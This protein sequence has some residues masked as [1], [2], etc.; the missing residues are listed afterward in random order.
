MRMAGW[1]ARSRPLLDFWSG[2]ACVQ[3][4]YVRRTYRQVAPECPVVLVTDSHR[5]SGTD[6][7]SVTAWRAI[8]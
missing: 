8:G 2:V 3:L 6:Y 4:Y 5:Q 7:A 1:F